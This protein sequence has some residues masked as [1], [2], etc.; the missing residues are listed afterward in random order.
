MISLQARLLRTMPYIS[1]IKQNIQNMLFHMLW[2]FLR[3]TFISIDIYLN[4]QIMKYNIGQKVW[5]FKY[6]SIQKYFNFILYSILFLTL[7][8][9]YQT[10]YYEVKLKQTK[11]NKNYKRQ[12]L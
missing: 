3:T 2:I 9:I 5:I 12:F 11:Y 10:V 1:Q 7:N 6:N 8:N 4:F